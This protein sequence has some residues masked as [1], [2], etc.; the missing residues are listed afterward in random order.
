MDA[1][2]AVEKLVGY[3]S[4]KLKQTAGLTGMTV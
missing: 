1:G 4:G 3:R 2:G